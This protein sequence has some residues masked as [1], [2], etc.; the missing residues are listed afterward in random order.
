[1]LGAV[2]C[3]GHV[4]NAAY[5]SSTIEGFITVGAEQLEITKRDVDFGAFDGAEVATIN[6][7]EEMMPWFTGGLCAPHCLDLTIEDYA[8]IEPI[9]LVL[10]EAKET[11]KFIREHHHSLYLWRKYASTM[12]KNPGDTRFAT[13]FIMLGSLLTNK[14]AARQFVNDP[15][16]LTWLQGKS[17]VRGV[18][19]VVF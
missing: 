13:H 3:S 18:G 5:N 7:L 15:G 17:R 1:M 2:D 12:V 4:K 14:A 8:K 16:Y 9:K 10:E 19:F 11:V 6:A